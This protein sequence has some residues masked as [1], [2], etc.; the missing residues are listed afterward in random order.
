M[1]HAS[2]GPT[3]ESVVL[4]IMMLKNRTYDHSAPPSFSKFAF[5]QCN[6]SM[7]SET[8]PTHLLAG[9]CTGNVRVGSNSGLNYVIDVVGTSTPHHH[10]LVCIF[11]TGF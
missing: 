5:V 3:P 10:P 4:M 1:R 11:R 2:W 8:E 9:W 7:S 6:E